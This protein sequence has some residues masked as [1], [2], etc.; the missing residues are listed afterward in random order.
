[1][2][3]K[4]SATQLFIGK[5]FKGLSLSSCHIAAPQD[6]ETIALGFLRFAYNFGD[7]KLVQYVT[8]KLL[9][10]LSGGTC[11]WQRSSLPFP[12]QGAYHCSSR[13]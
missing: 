9:S 4:L 12:Q 7:E 6:S 2:V 11:P 3:R 5:R 1:M 10:T 13:S 8:Y